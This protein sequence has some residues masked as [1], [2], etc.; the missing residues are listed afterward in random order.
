[1]TVVPSQNFF[2]S[3]SRL[4]LKGP[5]EPDVVAHTYNLSQHSMRLQENHK[6]EPSLDIVRPV[7]KE[8]LFVAQHK[9]LGSILNLNK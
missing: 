2:A 8:L 4:L 9:D 7:L 6:F 1:M 5:N 3:Y